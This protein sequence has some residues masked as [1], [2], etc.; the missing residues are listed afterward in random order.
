MTRKFRRVLPLL[1]VLVMVLSLSV[2]AKKPTPKKTVLAEAPTVEA[3]GI[4]SNPV[5]TLKLI[6]GSAT[7]EKGKAVPGLFV[8][9]DPNQIMVPG[10][11]TIPVVFRPTN[12]A[13]YAPF[14]FTVKVHSYKL[15]LTVKK[16]PTVEDK[17]L[18]VNKPVSELELKD[19]V[20]VN[21]FDR[22]RD[23]IEGHFEFLDPE[24][25][26]D[27]AGT[28]EVA[29]VFKPDNSDLYNDA[30]VTYK[31][32]ANRNFKDAFVTVTVE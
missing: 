9:A 29:V 18:G 17:K 32:D 24:Q 3:V 14:T 20:A 19:G 15:N 11:H 25:K 27:K 21:H 22:S 10:I 23:S 26:F 16:L 2:S 1:L 30:T 7:T 6:G 5:S 4:A 28:Y 12:S 13:K 31:R 8:W